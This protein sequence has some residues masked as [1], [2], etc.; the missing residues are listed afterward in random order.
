MKYIPW[1]W[2]IICVIIF[3]I[4][5][6]SYY[7][8]GFVRVVISFIGSA[9]AVVCGVIVS[10]FLA[11][12]VF[13]RF[14]RE[15]L[16]EA[17]MNYHLESDVT[18]SLAENLTH[19]LQSLPEWLSGILS[20][21]SVDT[22]QAVEIINSLANPDTTAIAESLM[23]KLLQPAFLSFLG[24]V[25]FLFVFVILLFVFR[26][27]ANLAGSLTNRIPLVHGLNRLLGGA[28]GAVNG[29]MWVF[30]LA[31]FVSLFIVITDNEVFALNREVVE[32][33]RLLS[34]AFHKVPF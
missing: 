9:A 23:E 10:R 33:T 29:L 4:N 32:Q 31:I 6:N 24:M 7:R 30:L 22:G 14:I 16:M 21:F 19:A 34:V 25:F 1:V 17:L 8:K 11:D 12:M 18:K 20:L 2:D 3:L 15:H 5:I 27:L 28:L 26:R 13:Q